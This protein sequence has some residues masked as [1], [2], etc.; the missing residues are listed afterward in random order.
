MVV[1]WPNLE[2]NNNKKSKSTFTAEFPT[3]LSAS[4]TLARASSNRSEVQKEV[5]KGKGLKVYSKPRTKQST[6]SQNQNRPK[7]QNT[8]PNFGYVVQN[9]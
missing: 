8:S 7:S 9:C 3:F 2:S 6:H 5:R 4:S 1:K